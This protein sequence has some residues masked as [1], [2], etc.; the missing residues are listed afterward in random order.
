ML[1]VKNT[2]NSIQ[3]LR[4]IAAL[5]VV[6]FHYREALNL[7][8]PTLGDTLFINGAI[9]VDLFFLISGFITFYVANNL[10]DGLRCSSQPTSRGRRG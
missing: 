6:G 2:I 4:G 9:G 1:A 7:T 5:L 10:N 3:A 8:F